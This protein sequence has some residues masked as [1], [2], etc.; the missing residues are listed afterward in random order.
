MWDPKKLKEAPPAPLPPRTGRV[1]WEERMDASASETGRCCAGC[2][3]P[4]IT[5]ESLVKFYAS[6]KAPR[7]EELWHSECW[8]RK[9][10]RVQPPLDVNALDPHMRDLLERIRGRF[11]TDV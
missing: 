8:D 1:G 5:T 3:A 9:H 6:L 11:P 7:S 4:I 2:G 10:F